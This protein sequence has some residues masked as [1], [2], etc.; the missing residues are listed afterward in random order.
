M[1]F[2]II[3]ETDSVRLLSWKDADRVDAVCNHFEIE[4]S[5]AEKELL[6]DYLTKLKQSR[7]AKVIFHHDFIE[8]RDSFIS[9]IEKTFSV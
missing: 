8:E 9:L 1:L 2:D 7:R 4:L 6:I 3:V 5:S